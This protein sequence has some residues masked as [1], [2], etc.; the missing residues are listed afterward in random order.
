MSHEKFFCP[1]PPRNVHLC[2]IP[3]GLRLNRWSGLMKRVILISPSKDIYSHWWA[4]PIKFQWLGSVLL[5][6]S[7]HHL[8]G[9][10]NW[11]WYHCTYFP[12]QWAGNRFK[13]WGRRGKGLLV[14][15]YSSLKDVVSLLPDLGLQ[16]LILLSLAAVSE[17]SFGNHAHFLWQQF[18][19]IWEYLRCIC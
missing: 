13:A 3:P 4:L 2:A 19:N 5:A 14:A 18:L 11:L 15:A 10:R 7:S 17:S 8:F 1:F 12:L 6:S 16:Q 9:G